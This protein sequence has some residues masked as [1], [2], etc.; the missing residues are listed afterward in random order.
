M[1]NGPWWR[2]PNKRG[3]TWKGGHFV[4]KHG[5]P[6]GVVKS[7]SCILPVALLTLSAFAGR[8]AARRLTKR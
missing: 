7:S 2:D 8:S 4:D 3:P 5:N 1:S 6:V